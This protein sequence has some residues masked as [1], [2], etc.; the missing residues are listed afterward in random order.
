M[1]YHTLCFFGIA[2]LTLSSPTPFPQGTG[3]GADS[4]A[5]EALDPATWTN[6]KIDDFL[7][8]A[9]KYYTR[10]KTNNVQ[11]L[12]NSFGAP[13]FFCGL[14]NFCNAGQPCLPIK[15]PAWYVS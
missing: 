11:S 4:C 8:E 10:T 2:S 7:V 1:R 3:A 6:L 14:D 15:L 5:S 12:A 13:N 9:A